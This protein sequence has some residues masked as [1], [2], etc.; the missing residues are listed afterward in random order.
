ME[1]NVLNAAAK[2]YRGK[3]YV[4]TTDFPVTEAQISQAIETAFKEG[5][6][7]REKQRGTCYTD[8]EI[9][10]MLFI[11]YQ[12]GYENAMDKI[13]TIEGKSAYDV[14]SISGAPEQRK[15]L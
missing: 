5:A 6:R 1:L 11:N 14:L 12:R 7:W 4:L 15:K 9:A 3:K 2:K 13:R 10:D 8:K